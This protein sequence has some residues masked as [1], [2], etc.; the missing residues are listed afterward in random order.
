VKIW[1]LEIFFLIW[2]NCKLEVSKNTSKL[3]KQL[4]RELEARETNLFENNAILCAIFLDLRFNVI[5]SA[6]QKDIC[7]SLLTNIYSQLMS[8]VETSLLEEDNSSFN[9]TLSD[10]THEVDAYLK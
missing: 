3:A 9:A 1:F 5:L 6:E 7:I 2:I 8:L 4:Y 10:S